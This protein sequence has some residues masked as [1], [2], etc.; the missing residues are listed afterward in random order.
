VNFRHS[1]ADIVHLNTGAAV[2]K[3]VFHATP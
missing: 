2:A 1:L 3:D